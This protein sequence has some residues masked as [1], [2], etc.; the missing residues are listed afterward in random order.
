M[1]KNVCEKCSYIFTIEDNVSDGGAGSGILE[2][3]ADEELIK[4][5]YFHSFAFP[6][7]FIEHGTRK[8]L[9]ERYRLDSE[10]IYSEIKKRV[11]NNG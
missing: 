11:E 4:N 7:K 6:D 10:S 3:L 2:K 9:F 5:I 1:L 8:E